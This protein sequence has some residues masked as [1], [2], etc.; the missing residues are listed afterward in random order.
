MGIYTKYLKEREDTDNQL[1]KSAEDALLNG[2]ENTLGVDNLEQIRVVLSEILARFGIHA[3][4]IRGAKSTEE[5][6]DATL[7][8]EDIMYEKIDIYDKSRRKQANHILAF[9]EDSTPV[10]L[11]PSVFGY[12]YINPVSDT[13]GRVSGK[14][15]LQKDAYV[16]FRPLGKGKFSLP[17]LLKLMMH[18]VAPSDIPLIVLSSLGAALLGLVA[19]SMNKRVLSHVV[20][21]GEGMIPYLLVS[22]TVFVLAGLA[23]G[24]LSVINTLMLGRMKQRISAQMQTAIVAKLLLMPYSYFEKNDT[25]KLSNQIRNG[26]RITDLIINFVMNNLLSTIFSVVYIPQMYTLAPELV[27]PALGV[28]LLQMVLSIVLTIASSRHTEHRIAMQQVTDSFLYEVLKGIQKIQNMGAQKR[29][30]AKMADNYR[31]NLSAELSPPWYIMLN[32]I[33][34]SAITIISSVIILIIAALSSTSQVD[35][36][37][38]TASYSLISTS[39]TS[40]V[41]MCNSVVTM[42]PLLMQLKDLLRVTD[43]ETGVEYVTRLRGEIEIK[44]LCFSYNKSE[45][46]CIDNISLHI[47]PGEKIAFVG[48][49]GCGKSTLLKLLL[50][51]IEPDSGSVLYDGKPLAT[52]NKRSLRKRIASVFQFTR[53]FP[54]TIYDNICFTTTDATEDIAWQAA[55]QAAIADDIRE[56]PLGMETD[57][58][59]GNGGGFS[60]G[61][62]QRLMLARAFAQNP[63]ILIMDEA[64]SAL[65]NI[66]QQKVLDSVYQMNSTVLMVAHRLSTVIGCDRIIMLKN[67]VIAEEG[68]YDTLMKHDGPFAELV[69]KQQIK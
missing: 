14:L 47:M 24:A 65:D 3:R 60:G 28:L 39:L 1:A 69:R 53:T 27:W 67:G 57:I 22:A 44:D 5:L 55:E 36:I 15:K 62:K 23:K 33:I 7:D 4:E 35:Y 38:F 10:L 43:T 68:D 11:V 42:K 29:V 50:G 41:S 8:P 19:P 59:E 17:K 54:G 9:L 2:T 18:L 66:S 31:K 61:Q 45:H 30:Y 26:S 64:T 48:E 37:A 49:S 6:L 32:E 21:I 58:S 63:S 51:M 16:I 46:G 56:L 12:R 34:I 13:K 20:Q 25:G 40:L 52:L